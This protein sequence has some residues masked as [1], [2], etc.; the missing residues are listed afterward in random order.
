MHVDPSNEVLAT[1]T[2]SGEYHDWIDGVEIPVV[3][4]RR[5]GN[6]R[7]LFE[8][9]EGTFAEGRHVIHIPQEQAQA[10]FDEIVSA[11]IFGL[12]RNYLYIS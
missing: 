1:T 5:F 7:V 2:F 10:M 3:W 11:D 12:E 4:K 6:G 8:G 9:I